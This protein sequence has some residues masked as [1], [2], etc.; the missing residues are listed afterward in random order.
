MRC[1]LKSHTLAPFISRRLFIACSIT[2][3]CTCLIS[4]CSNYLYNN[5]TDK[6]KRGGDC[7]LRENWKRD[8]LEMLIVQ[9]IDCVRSRHVPRMTD[10]GKRGRCESRRTPTRG[11]W[12]APSSSS[13]SSP[14]SIATRVSWRSK[15][16]GET[17]IIHDH[18]SGQLVRR[19]KIIRV[20]VTRKENRWKENL[21]PL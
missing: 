6:G 11:L 21:C 16:T 7:V 14:L 20:N 17:T 1:S 4:T 8:F 9:F 10:R 13:P 15:I 18:E 5:N 2:R 12:I 19:A 3:G